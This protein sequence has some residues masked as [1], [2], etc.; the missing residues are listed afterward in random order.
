M[1]SYFPRIAVLSIITVMFLSSTVKLHGQTLIYDAFIRGDKVGEMKVIREVNDEATKIIVDTHIEAHMLVKIEVDFKS[2]ST[3]MDN[4]L[5]LGKAETRTNGHLKSSVYTV[6]KDGQYNIDIDGESSK[7]NKDEL[8]G[9]DYYY[10]EVPENGAES[11]A[12]ATGGILDMVKEDQ[13]E[14][15]FE[16]DDKKEIH[17]FKNGVLH[18]LEISHRFYTI[19]FKRRL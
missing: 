9:A 16:H 11:Y 3:Y 1:R 8:V 6:L 4:K 18:E 10:F 14:F 13:N 7:I 19:T 5:L 17:T 12:L 15:Y 2:S